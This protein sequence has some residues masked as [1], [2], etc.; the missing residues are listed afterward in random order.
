MS[1]LP[2][3]ILRAYPT[4][5]DK[6]YHY[7]AILL[8]DGKVLEVKNP[9]TGTKATYESLDTWMEWHGDH[10]IA[11]DTSKASRYIIPSTGVDGLN[12][13]TEKN[14]AYLWLQWLYSIVYEFAPHLLK[15][16]DFV[17]AYNTMV[18]LA[19]KHKTELKHFENDFKGQRK[20]SPI[21]EVRMWNPKWEGYKGH[22]RYETCFYKAPT[23]YTPEKYN[24]ARAEILAAFKR[25][26][27]I[28]EPVIGGK[29][30]KKYAF[31]EALKTVKSMEQAI[32]TS[33][34]RIARYEALIAHEKKYIADTEHWL[35]LRKQEAFTAEQAMLG[36]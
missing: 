24:D 2:G 32:K 16:D 28:V 8:K 10:T 31:L 36:I 35:P 1:Y 21:G 23:H 34:K 6:G 26:C 17:L 18:E 4:A 3:T 5:D 30:A 13:P 7:T 19:T 27:E 12:Y 20:Y 14:P 9:V 29:M 22:F 15:S 11:A 25:I 33:Q